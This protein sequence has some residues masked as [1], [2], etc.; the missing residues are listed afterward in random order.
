[1]ILALLLAAAPLPIRELNPSPYGKHYPSIIETE[2]FQVLD[3]SFKKKLVAFR[4][5]YRL[6][7]RDQ[8]TVDDEGRE[9]TVAPEGTALK[10]CAY[11]GMTDHPYAGLIVGLYDLGK[12]KLI[13]AVHI[14]EST[15]DSCTTEEAANEAKQRAEKVIRAAGLDPR[16]TA[17]VLDLPKPKN[18]VQTIVLQGKKRRYEMTA[19]NVRHPQDDPPTV[20]GNE[21]MVTAGV[22]TFANASDA[23]KDANKTVWVRCQRDRYRNA[24]GGAFTY[25]QAVIKD[26]QLVLV[27]K[28]HHSS[29]ETDS[30]TRELWSFTR[31]IKLK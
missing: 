24:S 10:R 25:P 5:V 2:V 23:K 22:I 20:C 31:I 18:G 16:G 28:F 17:Q 9:V 29:F 7:E 26:D 21:P 30:P 13:G 6:S 12:D 4:H 11:P 19:T 1:M 3:V 15:K 14:Y 27:E 8:T